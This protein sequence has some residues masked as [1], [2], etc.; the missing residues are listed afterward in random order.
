[1]VPSGGQKQ[2]LA[3]ARAFLRNPSI[4]ILDEATSA[5]DSRAEQHIQ[6]ALERL[7]RNRTSIV[8]AHRLS[9]ILNADKIVVLEHGHIV[10]MG[11]HRKLLAWALCQSIP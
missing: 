4:L 1:M 8:I 11:P 10:E 9:T 7:L 6:Q 5:L 3:L 2:R